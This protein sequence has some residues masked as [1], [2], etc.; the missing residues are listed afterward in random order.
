M[1]KVL[2]A[3]LLSLGLLGAMTGTAAAAPPEPFE[4]TCNGVTYVITSAAGQW[5]VGS[6][7][8]SSTH[9]IPYAIDFVVT[10]AA[11]N[12]VFEDTLTKG[13]KAHQNQGPTQ[14]C[15]FSDTFEE[16]GQVL[17]VSGTVQVIVRP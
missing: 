12:V 13:G 17:T 6:V 5:A 9:F 3:G 2:G 1:R 15:M 7:V 16:D 4:L 11:G 14:S 8:D 10:D